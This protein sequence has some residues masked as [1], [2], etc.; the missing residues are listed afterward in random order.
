MDLT[1]LFL[2]FIG[3]VFTGNILGDMRKKLGEVVF[4]VWKGM[5][6]GRKHVKARD[7]KTDAQLAQRLFFK[8]VFELGQDLNQSFII[9]FWKKFA[10]KKTELNC[11]MS[12]NLLNMSNGE[13][14]PNLSYAQGS[15]FPTASTAATYNT[16]TGEIIVTFPTTLQGDQA[17]TD[18]PY[19]VVLDKATGALYCNVAENKTRNDGTIGMS[20]ISGKTATDILTYLTFAN[21]AIG[22]EGFICS[23]SYYKVCAAP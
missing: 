16:A 5:Q 4:F 23:N 11:F 7:A 19:L 8:Q 9:P 13:D 21:V 22:E 20:I 1:F 10:I 18:I 3:A 12:Y 6:V 14:Y 2:L 17:L 15:L